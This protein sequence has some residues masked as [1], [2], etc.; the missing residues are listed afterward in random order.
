M[1]SEYKQEESKDPLIHQ[2][3]G[4]S[5]PIDHQQLQCDVDSV[6][7]GI[8]TDSTYGVDVS[9]EGRWVTFDGTVDTQDTRMA[10]FLLVPAQNGKRLIVDRLNVAYDFS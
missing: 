1:F 5:L 7:G 10:L 3:D 4:G 8:V 6:L 2:R 9:V